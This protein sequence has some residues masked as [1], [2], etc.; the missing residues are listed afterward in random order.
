M[1]PLSLEACSCSRR[2]G[3][4]TCAPAGGPQQQGEGYREKGEGEGEGEGDGGAR[5]KVR[6]RL[7]AGAR[8]A[9]GDRDERR[10]SAGEGAVEGDA[11]C[12]SRSI[13]VLRPSSSPPSRTTAAATFSHSWI[14]WDTQGCS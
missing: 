13:W 7:G 14:T 3:P 9:G 6:V 1:A 5:A 11:A 12:T 2:F 10:E 4:A 8:G